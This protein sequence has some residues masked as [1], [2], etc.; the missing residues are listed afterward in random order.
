MGGAI[1]S[2]LGGGII[3]LQ[4][5][6]IIPELGAASS[7]ISNWRA[8]SRSTLRIDNASPTEGRKLTMAR[9]R[10][11]R[12]A[13]PTATCQRKAFGRPDAGSA[14]QG[15]RQQTGRSRRLPLK[16][17]RHGSRWQKAANTSEAVL[18]AGER[19][20]KPP[21]SGRRSASTWCRET[22]RSPRRSARSGK[23]LCQFNA[24]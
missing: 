10:G 18:E 12:R 17:P 15:V 8:I 9:R 23:G 22:C 13:S 1:I 7:G 4:G 6:G 2:E 19:P 3:P 21:L 16:A 5:G 20:G 24:M 14:P 11:K